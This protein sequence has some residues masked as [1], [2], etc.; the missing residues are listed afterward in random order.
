MISP[1]ARPAPRSRSS[2]AART[3]RSPSSSCTRARRRRPGA[4]LRRPSGRPAV[5]STTAATSSHSLA[6]SAARRASGSSWVAIRTLGSVTTNVTFAGLRRRRR[7]VDDLVGFRPTSSG[8]AQYGA[9]QFLESVA[10]SVPIFISSCPRRPGSHVRLAPDRQSA[11]ISWR[12]SRSRNGARRRGPELRDQIHV[13]AERQTALMRS[14]SA[15]RRSSSRW[16]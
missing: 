11:S 9:P 8:A 16:R 7:R 14:S 15:A 10:R 12:R 4:V 1:V 5:T 3:A 6:R 2:N 13:P